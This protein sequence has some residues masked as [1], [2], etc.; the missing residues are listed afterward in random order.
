[1]RASVTDPAAFEVLF[2]RYHARIWAL[3]ARSGGRDHA[4]DLAGEVFVV[5]FRRRGDYD[6]ARGSVRAWSYGIASNVSRTQAPA[7]AAHGLCSHAHRQV[8]RCDRDPRRHPM[9]PR[10]VNSTGSPRPVASLCA[11]YLVRRAD[12]ARRFLGPRALCER[13]E[14]SDAWRRFPRRV[15]DPTRGAGVPGAVGRRQRD[16]RPHR[17]VSRAGRRNRRRNCG[18]RLR[19]AGVRPRLRPE[20]RHRMQRGLRRTRAR[21]RLSR[22]VRAD[23]VGG[24]RARS[25]GAGLP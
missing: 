5:G 11:A 24:F 19:E 17:V 21:V 14:E 10:T 3:L 9:M 6:P 23:I 1:M 8:T 15:G 4:D 18:Q 22:S 2:D 25:G 16:R 20:G 12:G 13:A 7:D